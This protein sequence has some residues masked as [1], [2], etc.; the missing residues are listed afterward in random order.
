MKRRTEKLHFGAA[1]P[2]LHSCPRI[3]A[4]KKSTFKLS[5]LEQ[6][7]KDKSSSI[8]NVELRNCI[9]GAALPLLHS[10]PRINA[11]KSQ[12]LNYRV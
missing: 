3:N 2:F 9:F 7:T 12:L 4:Q 1:L 5:G 8:W 6:K 10:S 11:Q